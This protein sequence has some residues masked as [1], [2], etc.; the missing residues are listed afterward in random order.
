MKTLTLKNS[1]FIDID[2][3]NG[4]IGLTSWLAKQMLHGPASRNRTRFVKLVSDRLNEIDKEIQ[5]L[6][7]ECSAK[8]KKGNTIYFDKDGKETTEKEKAV[9]F[10][11]EDQKRFNEEWEKY[12]Q[13]NYVIDVTPAT[14]DIVY[15]VRDIV[16]NT[17]E[18]FS[19]A[20]AQR[21]DQWCEAFESISEQKES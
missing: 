7:E 3:Q 20:M 1:F 15:G 13:E 10:K 14:K 18:E 21:Y 12:M 11:I 6:R 4:I 17:M 16:L 19:G 9:R 2:P 5:K 8:D